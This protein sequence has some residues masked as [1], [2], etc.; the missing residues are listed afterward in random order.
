MEL[1]PRDLHQY[2]FPLPSLYSPSQLSQLE[3]V[4]TERDKAKRSLVDLQSEM[5]SLR[6]NIRLL[7]SE[8]DN[9]DALYLQVVVVYSFDKNV[10]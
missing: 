2:S 10:P 1:L 7:T 5:E 3:K 6:S 9:I 4:S 8:R